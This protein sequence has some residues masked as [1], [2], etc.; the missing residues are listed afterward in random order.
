[1]GVENFKDWDKSRPTNDADSLSQTKVDITDPNLLQQKKQE[2]KQEAVPVKDELND[3]KEQVVSSEKKDQDASSETLAQPNDQVQ[4]VID[5]LNNIKDQ[6]WRKTLWDHGLMMDIQRVLVGLGYADAKIQRTGRNFIDGYWW[7]ATRAAVAKFQESKQLSGSVRNWSYDGV[8]GPETLTAVIQTLS[9]QKSD[10]SLP[11]A[12]LKRP[13]K[14]RV[15]KKP[16][17]ETPEGTAAE[18]PAK[19]AE[20]LPQIKLSDL[21]EWQNNKFIFKQGVEK[22]D[23]KGKYIEIGGQRYDQWKEGLTWLGYQVGINSNDTGR[24]YLWAYINGLSTGKGKIVWRDGDVY[25]WDYK[26]DEMTGKGKYIFA[27]GITSEWVFE[28]GTFKS[29]KKTYH[30]DKPAIEGKFDANQGLIKEEVEEQE[31]QATETTYTGQVNATN[32]QKHGS[33]RTTFKDSQTE[34]GYYENGK[35]L[36]WG[37]KTG[38]DLSQQRGTVKLTEKYEANTQKQRYQDRTVESWGNKISLLDNASGY[39]FSTQ[40]GAK[41]TLPKS[42]WRQKALAAAN[43]INA[44]VGIVKKSGFQLDEFEADGDILQADYKKYVWDTNLIKNVQEKF[45]VSA[46]VLADW[47]N[48]YRK[49][50]GI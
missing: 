33:G 15:Q 11:T 10:F 28:K 48:K 32:K 31:D 9:E 12:E 47:M 13:S 46:T 5:D 25:E 14:S 3:L 44:A 2:E 6:D 39:H 16:K 23:Q 22:T 30:D 40:S 20:K 17:T 7:P 19:A 1:M 49:D 34:G 43:L 18:T 29:G 41:L 38:K 50:V 45:W 27:A 26:D 21:G 8:P 42:L 37:K 4:K 36:F 24:F 35:L